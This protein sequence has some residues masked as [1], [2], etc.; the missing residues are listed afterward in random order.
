MGV[1][2]NNCKVRDPIDTSKPIV[3]QPDGTEF[4]P[5]EIS[6]SDRA[7]HQAKAREAQQVQIED[8]KEKLP[9]GLR[10]KAIGWLKDK[11]PW[12]EAL[13]RALWDDLHRHE[14]SSDQAVNLA[15]FE[16]W[17]SHIPNFGCKCRDHFNDLLAKFPP[18]LDKP[19]AM[20]LW[21]WT[22]H[23]MVN[24]KRGAR[25]F[26]YEYARRTYG[27]PSNYPASSKVP[28]KLVFHHHLS[29][30][31]VLM[32]T[33]VLEDL[34][35][36]YSGRFKTDTR[37]SSP[38]IFTNNP[39]ITPIEPDDKEARHIQLHYPQYQWQDDYPIHFAEAMTQYLA[40]ELNIEIPAIT[41]RPVLY[42]SEAEI[43]NRPFEESY[44]LITSGGKSDYTC[45][46]PSMHVLQQAIDLMPSI[47]FL[48][49]G[50]EGD[51]GGGMVH[52]QPRLKG[53][54][55]IDLVGRTP[56]QR[57]L[58]A[59]AYHAEGAIAP[60]TFLMHVAGALR[61]PAIVLAGGRE[62][63][64][65]ERYPEHTY[66]HSIG[67]LPCC[68]KRACHKLRTVKLED[69]S[70]KNQGLCSLPIFRTG[71]DPTPKCQDRIA[72]EEIVS[73]VLK[74]FPQVA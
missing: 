4:N 33:A 14:W 12:I 6:P 11:F 46:W 65:W 63:P 53:K 30:G 43:A 58:F 19:K 7:D 25:E 45:K 44:W 16:E 38:A 21:T 28:T 3:H 40:D 26:P 56:N 34:H 9:Q 57:D 35:A 67:A 31:D 32:V 68:E 55:V 29:P 39:W 27:W 47:T 18:P 64:T 41:K 15:W 48:Q 24:R 5:S 37:T 69:G 49:V 51:A 54:N 70:D 66:L 73:V 22:I 62:A 17:K 61:K 2:K 13:G 50:N 23:N 8:A 36:A 71:F 74:S 10:E 42:L 72:P 1:C 20:P 59:L 60:V 52:T